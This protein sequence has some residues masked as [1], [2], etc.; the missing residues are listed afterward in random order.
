MKGQTETYVKT[1]LK[2]RKRI[3]THGVSYAAFHRC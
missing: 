3:Q 2:M 1:A